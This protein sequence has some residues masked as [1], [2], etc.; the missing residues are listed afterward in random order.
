[1]NTKVCVLVLLGGC[2]VAPSLEAATEFSVL[3]YGAIPT[4]GDPPIQLNSTTI[5]RSSTQV[6]GSGEWPHLSGADQLM[7]RNT[8]YVAPAP[9]YPP[10]QYYA[11]GQ[12]YPGNYAPV[13]PP[14]QYYAPPYYE[15]RFYPPPVYVR[16]YYDNRYCIRF[17]W[18]CE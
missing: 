7:L 15:R 5:Q 12:G 17:P 13:P 2:M 3:G 9:G 11:P 10:G 8:Q 14:P 16:P 4:I 1:M 6:L 18:R